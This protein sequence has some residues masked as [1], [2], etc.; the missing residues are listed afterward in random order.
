MGPQ[1]RPA[2]TPRPEKV[3]TRTLVGRLPSPCHIPCLIQCCHATMT[4]TVPIV[5]HCV[6][7]CAE[8]EPRVLFPPSA[9]HLITTIKMDLITAVGGEQALE[10]IVDLAVKETVHLI[11]LSKCCLW[12]RRKYN[13]CLKEA[14]RPYAPR[15]R[16]KTPPTQRC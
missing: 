14:L 9:S 8:E 2:L 4:I 16:R 12:S 3:I 5:Y 10:M 13:R 7:S 6:L 15:R 11:L 1:G